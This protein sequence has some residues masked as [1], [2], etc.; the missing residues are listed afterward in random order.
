[1][2]ELVEIRFHG[3]G[4][5][6]AWTSSRLLAEAALLEGKHAQSFPEFGP[7]RM[8]APIQAFTRISDAPIRIHSQ[9]YEPDYVVVLDRSLLK[10]VKVTDG[11]KKALILNSPPGVEKMPGLNGIRVYA[12]PATELSLKILKRNAPST[13]VLGALIKV[14]P[15]VSMDSLLEVTGERFGGEI[16]EKN[17]EVI[18]RAY[19]EVRE[20]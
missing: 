11:L 10:T 16:G 2:P 19:D 9:V 8:G 18:R 7:E 17:R 3:R 12:T 6:G 14:A 5:Q 15:L 1:M 4:G 20:L 13:A